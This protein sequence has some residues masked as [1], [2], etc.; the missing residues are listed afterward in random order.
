MIFSAIKIS[1]QLGEQ[2]PED[3]DSGIQVDGSEL[4]GDSWTATGLIPETNYSFRVC[5]VDK[6]PIP[7]ISPGTVMTALTLPDLTVTPPDPVG[8]IATPDSPTQITLDW[9]SG[10]R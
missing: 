4:T 2:A 3:C 8:L 1:Y 7:D 6:K 5:T 9:S 10:G